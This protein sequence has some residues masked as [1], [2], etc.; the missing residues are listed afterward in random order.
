[1]LGFDVPEIEING[2]NLAYLDQG[3]GPPIVA[4]HGWGGNKNVWRPQIDAFSRTHRFIAIDLPG[5]GDSDRPDGD[6][7]YSPAACADMTRALMDRLGLDRA[8]LLGQSMGTFVS[9]LIYHS[10]PRRVIALVLTG[11]LSRSPPAGKIAGIWVEDIVQEIT[12]RGIKDYLD[13]NVRFWFS[14]GF[15][16]ARIEETTAER[17]KLAAHAAI[18]YCRAVAVLDIRDRLG[19]IRVPTLIIVGSEDG[20]TP[21]EEGELMNR[22][23]PDAWLKVIKGAGHLVNVEQPD[24]FN[25]PVL[26]F[27]NTICQAPGSVRCG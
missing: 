23:I 9:Q 20:R 15:D 4:I 25:K 27:I 5:H 14:P 8:I 18:A 17:Y 22:G 16:P 7:F 11:A 1:V 2:L 21:V 13:D 26:D 19:E 24:A 6:H 10:D 12:R 3:S